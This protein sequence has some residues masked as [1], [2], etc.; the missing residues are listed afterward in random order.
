MT[1]SELVAKAQAIIVTLCGAV[2]TL[3]WWERASYR[4]LIKRVAVLDNTL[5]ARER[6]LS[7]AKIA[8]ARAGAI[9]CTE[10]LQHYANAKE[11]DQRCGS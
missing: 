4:A 8:L 6:E 10:C 9:M 11:G 1:E 5:R 7:E 2:A 3:F